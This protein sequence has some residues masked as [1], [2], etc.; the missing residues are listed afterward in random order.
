VVTFIEGRD[1]VRRIVHGQPSVANFERLFFWLREHPTKRK[2]VRD[3]ADFVAHSKNRNRGLAWDFASALYDSIKYHREMQAANPVTKEVA[4][5]HLKAVQLL[6]PTEFPEERLGISQDE[7]HQ[8]LRDIIDRFVDV[9]GVNWK[10]RPKLNEQEERVWRHYMQAF[11]WQPAFTE[12]SLMNDLVFVLSE[13]DALKEGEVADFKKSG[14]YLGKFVITRMHLSVMKLG[15]DRPDIQL[16]AGSYIRPP[17]G[18]P[19]MRVC[20]AIGDPIDDRGP[21]YLVSVFEGH[22]MAVPPDV[23]D[24]IR[25][26]LECGPP[27]VLGR[28]LTLDENGVLELIYEE[29]P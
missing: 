23:T 8:S 9:D 17:M 21:I 6:E 7:A 28:P 10:F 2:S 25:F 5:A 3:V 1:V 27:P 29:T 12:D 18:I 22:C 19:Y 20:A 11:A 16:F 15:E 4:I 26:W 24:G 13:M 14:H